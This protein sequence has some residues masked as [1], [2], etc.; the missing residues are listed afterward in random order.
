MIALICV[1]ALVS[2]ANLWLVRVLA[3][4]EDDFDVPFLEELLLTA[5]SIIPIVNLLALV[6]SVLILVDI[7]RK[8]YQNKF[9]KKPN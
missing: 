7:Y 4:L 2:V 6:L 5:V 9:Q 1:W 3:K 8:K